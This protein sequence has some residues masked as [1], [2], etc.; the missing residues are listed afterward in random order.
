MACS[1]ATTSAACT[2]TARV[3]S[4]KLGRLGLHR[5]ERAWVRRPGSRWVEV[6]GGTRLI[7]LVP[8]G[9]S[10]DTRILDLRL[11]SMLWL[12]LRFGLC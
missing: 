9:T 4:A 8:Y 3:K 7:R 2:L 10:W 12:R 5:V 11:R 6:T 1:F